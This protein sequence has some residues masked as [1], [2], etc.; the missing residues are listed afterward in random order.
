MDLS[1]ISTI[2]PEPQL[3]IPIVVLLIFILIIVVHN[4][5]KK[6]R[7]IGNHVLIYVWVFFFIAFFGIIFW[8]LKMPESHKEISANDFGFPLRPQKDSVTYN[9]DNRH[10]TASFSNAVGTKIELHDIFIQDVSNPKLVCFPV[11]VNGTNLREEP[12][13]V[14]DKEIFRIDADCSGESVEM[15]PGE[16][17]KFLMSIRYRRTLGGN[18][19]LNME[20]NVTGVVE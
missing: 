12:Y 1:I 4:R 2:L 9:S 14:D 19:D 13:T 17:F 16:N 7:K 20:G 15:I 5:G 18:M 8:G 3:S 11:H 10:F 6:S